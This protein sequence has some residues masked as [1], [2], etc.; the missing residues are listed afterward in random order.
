MLHVTDVI[1]FSP[2]A[3]YQNANLVNLKAEAQKRIAEYQQQVSLGG[4][5]VPV[6]DTWS[7]NLNRAYWMEWLLGE[8]YILL[9]K[10]QNQLKVMM[11]FTLLVVCSFW[12]LFCYV[13]CDFM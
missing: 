11:M 10:N 4:Y 12:K 2:F 6:K 8:I 9:K 3:F 7:V 5:N 1:V 13:L